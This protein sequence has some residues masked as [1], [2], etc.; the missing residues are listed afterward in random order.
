MTS[1]NGMNPILEQFIKKNNGNIFVD[2]TDFSAG[3]AATAEATIE[4]YSCPA[5]AK[6]LVGMRPVEYPKDQA[7]AE[8]MMAVFSLQGDYNHMPYEVIGGNIAPSILAT[9]GMLTSPSEFFEVTAPVAGGQ[10]IDVVIEPLDAIAG[11]RDSAVEF[12][13]TDIDL[14][15]LGIPI[16]YS[17]ASREV[18]LV[19]VG[20]TDG[21]TLELTDFSVLIEI[22]A[23]FTPAALTV[24]EEAN[25]QLKITCTSLEHQIQTITLEPSGAIADGTVDENSYMGYLAR[26]PCWDRLRAGQGNK[27]TV[28]AQFD[29]SIVL[30]AAGQVAHYLR[31]I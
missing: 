2:S 3:G 23:V 15:S 19:N 11:D 17:K 20:K 16:Q 12:T 13:F 26:R 31:W 6:T 30:S 5:D 14:H 1:K 24:E 8:S 28:T 9:G 27:V 10:K 18:A 4:E 25:V 29:L 7:V 22:G 21:T